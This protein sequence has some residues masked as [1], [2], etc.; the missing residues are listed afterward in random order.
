[1]GSA[2]GATHARGA[3]ISSAKVVVAMA[4]HGHGSGAGSA[5]AGGGCLA[6]ALD[7]SL[8][9]GR[10]CARCATSYGFADGFSTGAATEAGPGGRRAKKMRARKT[11]LTAAVFISLC[12]PAFAQSQRIMSGSAGG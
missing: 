8:E 11:M 9:A 12:L 7:P 5:G 2:A 3:H 6:C 10:S 4:I 1:M